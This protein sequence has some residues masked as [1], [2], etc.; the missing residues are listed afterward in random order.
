MLQSRKHHNNVNTDCLGK[1]DKLS[2]PSKNANMEKHHQE[3]IKETRVEKKHACAFVEV[4][5]LK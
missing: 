3:L 2:P 5:T 1:D 4:L